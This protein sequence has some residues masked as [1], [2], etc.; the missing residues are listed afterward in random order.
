MLMGCQ[1]NGVLRQDAHQ[2]LSDQF[3][4]GIRKSFICDFPDLAIGSAEG[5]ARG[6]KIRTPARENGRGWLN[7]VDAACCRG[8][9][10]GGISE[11]AVFMQNV[12]KD[13]RHYFNPPLAATNSR[14]FSMFSSRL[15][16]ED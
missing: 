1:Q 5:I 2:S 6:I 10:S 11:R 8:N 3:R 7:G 14:T 4:V 13:S 12:N 16:Q 9:F 15:P